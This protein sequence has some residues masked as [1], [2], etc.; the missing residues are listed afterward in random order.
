LA[1]ENF[2][3]DLTQTA[4]SQSYVGVFGTT[5]QTLSLSSVL[6]SLS[7]EAGP[8]VRWIRYHLGEPLLRV[9]LSNVQIFSAFE[10]AN[11]EYSAE[12]NKQIAKNWITSLLGTSRDFKIDKSNQLPYP[13]LNFLKDRKSVV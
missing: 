10:E 6:D 3:T 7:G 12:V 4:N 8:V 11:I 9:E 2:F 5:A 1:F 13:T